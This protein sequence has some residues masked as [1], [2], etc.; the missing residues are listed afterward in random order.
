M[1]RLHF[2]TGG[3]PRTLD[4]IDIFQTSLFD[5]IEAMFKDRGAFIIQGCSVTG[6]DI[7]AGIVFIDDEIMPF[8]GASGVT[9]PAYIKK[10]DDQLT[11]QAVYETGGSKPTQKHVLSELVSTIPNAGEY[12]SMTATGGRT[13]YDAIAGEVVRMK[14]NQTI[15]GQKSFT[16]EIIIG[17]KLL[18]TW[19]DN[20]VISNDSIP[21]DL[22]QNYTPGM[23]VI[24]SSHSNKPS[25]QTDG[26]LFIFSNGSNQHQ[27]FISFNGAMYRRSRFLGNWS[28][29]A[30][31]S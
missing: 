2:E 18:S 26:F 8:A 17:G 29:W 4:D 30:L 20:R 13:Y 10:A 27:L 11:A 16:S 24:S 15:S 22:N 28:N 21:S 5:A 19:F 31:M 14:G 1:K 9:F 23:H 12:I 6:N 3:R 25:G 7:S